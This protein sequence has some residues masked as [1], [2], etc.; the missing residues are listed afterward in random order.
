MDSYIPKL[1]L[2]AFSRLES[3]IFINKKA[4]KHVK[5]RL[6]CALCAKKISSPLY[7]LHSIITIF[8][9]EIKYPSLF[10]KSKGIKIKSNPFVPVRHVLISKKKIVPT[11][12]LHDGYSFPFGCT[13]VIN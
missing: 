1:C 11:E 8:T 12:C 5:I 13:K 3:A 7:K 4:K 2:C 9:K 10:V 6:Q